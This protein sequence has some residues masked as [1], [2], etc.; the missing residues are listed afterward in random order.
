MIRLPRHLRRQHLLAAATLLVLVPWVPQGTALAQA[1]NQWVN[2]TSGGPGGASGTMA[3]PTGGSVGV[4]FSGAVTNVITD[5][6][7]EPYWG[8]AGTYSGSGISTPPPNRDGI[9]VA[10]GAGSGT[11][12][13]S[14]AEAVNDPVLA[15]ASLGLT[16]ADRSVNIQSS[17]RF[18]QPF[19][20]LSNG[21]NYYAG[22]QYTN[23]IS[24]PGTP[25]I[26]YG[27]E[28]S[29]VIRF[30]G[31]F[32]Q[33]T[34]TSPDAELDEFGTVVGTYLF[35]LGAVPCGEYRL[36]PLTANAQVRLG[37]TAYTRGGAFDQQFQLDVNGTLRAETFY[38]L[39]GTQNVATSG[40]TTL[41][42]GGLI[43][44]TAALEV[45]G[46]LDNL[47]ALEVAGRLRTHGGSTWGS[48][49]LVVQPMADVVVGGV[50]TLYG[51]TSVNGLLKVAAGGNA[52]TLTPLL[53]GGTG[54]QLDVQAGGRLQAVAGL[55]AN[56]G[57]RLVVGGELIVSNSLELSGAALEVQAGG[58]L[59]SRAD[60]NLLATV[61]NAG[62]MSFEAGV[63]QM[64][65]GSLNNGGQFNISGAQVVLQGGVVA[66]NLTPG[67]LVLSGSGALGLSGASLTNQGLIDAQDASRLAFQT[68][69]VLNAGTLQTGAATE[70]NMIGGTLD[71]SGTMR[72][73]GY[74]FN[75]GVVTNNGQM[76]FRMDNAEASPF[77]AGSLVNNGTLIIDN[78]VLGP[79]FTNG[80]ILRNQGQF[81]IED[82]TGFDNAGSLFN[83][84]TLTVN[85]I[86]SISGGSL[87]QSPS[88]R[89]VVNGRL[90]TEGG[91]T[92]D[93]G[94]I[95]GSG[96]IEGALVLAA[97]ASALPGTSP[98]TLTV[99]GAVEIRDG[100]RLELEVG[101][102]GAHD[103]LRADSLFVSDGGVV[104]LSFI[105]GLAPDLDQTFE[106]LQ[107]APG[108]TAALRLD[109]LQ[110]LPAGLRADGYTRD[111]ASGNTLGLAFAPVGATAVQ[112]FET[113]GE[114]GLWIEAG[115][116][117]Y[118]DGALGSLTGP[119]QVD[120]T[121]GLRR[122]TRFVI[123]E[124]W[125][126]A[127]GRLLTSAEQ[128]E[129]TGRLTV[130][131]EFVQRGQTV[132]GAVAVETGGRWSNTGSF[133][134]G[135]PEPT[136]L[137]VFRNAG[138]VS[139]TGG[140][141]RNQAA[142]GERP[143]ID[144]TAGGRF[145]IAAGMS[146]AV[147]VRNAG[148]WVVAAGARVQDVVSFEQSAG[149][150]HV[151]GE[152][153]TEG[154]RVTAGQVSGHGRIEG[155][156]Q[157]AVTADFAEA[158]AIVLRPGAEGGLGGGVLRF[159]ERLQ[160]GMG[161]MLEFVIGA[162]AQLARLDLPAGADF[163]EGAQLRIVL[164]EGWRP[165]VDTSWLL[166]GYSPDTT[167][168]DGFFALVAP[169]AGVYAR[170]E[171]GDDFLDDVQLS[172]Q[173]TP[174][175]VAVTLLPV[176]AVP[177]PTTYGLMLAGLGLVG[178]LK[179]RREAAASA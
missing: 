87:V 84:G 38:T 138:E 26:L 83:N 33:I 162:D 44:P 42:Q 49:G 82:G 43:A 92:L 81:T 112:P 34:W 4:T 7:S 16:T 141:W 149:L 100:A 131:G 123:N 11:Y 75:N 25:N 122:D 35:T 128:F 165:T 142:G 146:G 118:A 136:A 173:L 55:T 171:A 62:T 101:R 37:C 132:A 98:G 143:L 94:S 99:L 14:F 1:G 23:F 166:L 170:T 129:H 90:S 58:S 130:A 51:A 151:D 144:N 137:P 169:G 86:A 73:S 114:F 145:D 59:S 36:E 21:P 110:G 70:L 119:L 153:Q 32:T 135:H 3:L 78:T 93:A 10:G 80:G 63:L 152:L 60:G 167:F 18:D 57:A 66:Q 161:T 91:L 52:T 48:A 47:T 12:T 6:F 71:N 77:N 125:V 40:R 95:G 9:F 150:L 117:R 79:S 121:L 53:V 104:A 159:T 54:A 69:T 56:S 174:D 5:N 102:S 155:P 115:Q 164:A 126:A 24:V 178:W 46:R 19:E 160:L 108:G 65:A 61:V 96:V 111:S 106:V 177:E 31:S 107:V 64:S 76:V 176:T 89:L 17:M 133:T 13:I 134:L 140:H 27:T 124:G 103:Q 158:G 154:L 147:D 15:I 72:V 97:G 157:L 39:A 105:D 85:G 67:R 22:G 88:G 50:A 41:Q 175:G 116:Q 20:V 45:N 30:R 148:R 68:A 168:V 179:R 2:W 74:F 109:T 29:G 127:G 120:G 156:V 163:D 113:A 8:P 139:H 28:S 172:F